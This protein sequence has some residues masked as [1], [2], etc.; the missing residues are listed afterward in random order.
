MNLTR[1]ALGHPFAVIALV[2]LVTAMGIVGYLRTPTELFPET[3]PPQVLVLTVQPGAGAEDVADKITEVIEKELNTLSGLVNLTSTSRDQ[4]SSVKAEFAYTKSLGEAVLDVQN[5]IAR[6]RAQLPD[7]ARQPRIYRINQEATRPLLTLALSPNE[8]SRKTLAHIRLLA[9]NQIKDALL[10]LPGVA[11]VDVF[12]GH[13]PEV[14]VHVDRDRLA[15]Y[16]VSLE[17]VVGLLAQR[18]VSVPAGILYTEERELLVRTG[19]EFADLQEIRNLPLLRPEH[20]L[21]RLSDVARVELGE[22]KARSFYHGN[23]RPAIA[24]N[25]LRPDGGRT[26]EA[27]ETVKRFL[28]RLQ[29]EYPD[30]RFEITDDQQ[31]LI[32]LNFSGMRNSIIQAI[33]LTVL[34]IFLFLANLRAALV[35]SISIPLAFLFSLAIIWLT[36]LRLNMV[37]LTG[38]IVA[39]GMVVDASVV[40][41]EN[42]YR[43]YEKMERPDADKAAQEGTNQIALAITA[44]MLTTVAVLLPIVFIGGYPQR[45]V[46]RVSL[47]VSTTLAASLVVA[48]TVVPLLASRLLGRSRSKNRLGKAASVGNRGI[49]AV[50]DFYLHILEKT[51]RWRVPTLLLAGLFFFITV[52][53]VPPLIGGELMP[54]MDTGI[55]VIDF[56]TP[57]TDVPGQVEAVLRRVE[58]IVYQEKGVER[59]SSVAG[60]EPGAI[61]F[62]GGGA[63]AQSVNIVIHLVPRTERQENIWQIQDRWRRKLR[64]VPGIQS[65]RVSEFGATPMSTTKAPLDII[66]SGPDAAVLDR[67]ADRCLQALRGT[68]GLED[69]R[70]SWYFDEQEYT[71]H[72]DP[73]LARVHGVSTQE[74]ARVLKTAVDGIPT[75]FM[76]LEKFLDIPVRVEYREQDKSLTSQL[77]DTY[78]PTRFGP[79][80]FRALAEMQVRCEQPFITREKLRATIDITGVNRGLTIGQ[81][82]HKVKQRLAEITRPRG[83]SIMVGGTVKDMKQTQK[84]LTR[85]LLIGLIL[86]YILLLA[87]FR[88]FLHPLTI[89]S[90]IPLAVAGGMWGLL[91]FDKPRCM[92]AN[93]G[94][95]FLAGTVINNSVLLLDFILQARQRGL[96]KNAAIREAVRL[97]LRPILMT[98]FST[99]VGLS[100]LVFEMAIGLE[101]MSPLAIVASTGLLFG[102]ITTLVVVPVVYSVMDSLGVGI[103]KAVGL[104]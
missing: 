97:R 27:I 74:T 46:G 48:L 22:E 53:I 44:G 51:L 1:A 13:T 17:E 70:R 58:D 59:V 61:S 89:L 52:R 28:P 66:I 62:G 82:A 41:L 26:V 50:R 75:S 73:A 96:D 10:G 92:P 64:R 76:R 72:V 65:F 84:R 104:R 71:V 60:S 3:A 36:P 93:M 91:L 67:L 37:T 4:V 5:A 94:I 14:K 99:V 95:I 8:A 39:I 24:L 35:V 18:N 69:V 20:G 32:D 98:T 25:I 11:D 2:L 90:A 42:I 43:R 38:L 31:P 103:G 19:G 86:L 49:E 80:P 29:T 101:R 16:G 21:L 77:L 23:G 40:A 6:V 9:E 83:Y 34:V 100:P 47:T 81:V 57:A 87:M 15:A 45:T 54:P 7:A 68:P 102:T 33:I 88:S 30:I 79:V 12:G 78:I 85:S 63:T 55:A 56:R